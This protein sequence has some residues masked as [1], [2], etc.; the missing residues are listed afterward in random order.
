M[1]LPRMVW[2]AS[3]LGLLPAISEA[4]RHAEYPDLASTVIHSAHHE[5]Q[6]LLC[7]SCGQVNDIIY[8]AERESFFASTY[9]GDVW[10]I[11]HHGQLI[12]VLRG[13]GLVP[14]SGVYF[15]DEHYIDWI[16]SGDA[17]PKAY[18]QILDADTLSENA[19]EELLTK[20]DYK[21]IRIGNKPD[22]YHYYLKQGDR[23]SLVSKTQVREPGENP[24]PPIKGLVYSYPQSRENLEP[25]RFVRLFPLQK[26]SNYHWES[27]DSP[28]RLHKFRR[29]GRSRSGFFDI[30]SNGWDGFYGRGQF[31]LRHL[32]ETL[33]FSAYHRRLSHGGEAGHLELYQLNNKTL[34]AASIGFLNVVG[35]RHHHSPEELGLYVIKPSRFNGTPAVMGRYHDLHQ[36][37]WWHT[38]FEGFASRPGKQRAQ[39]FINGADDKAETSFARRLPPTLMPVPLTLDFYHAL[40]EAKDNADFYV[41]FNEQFYVPRSSS[42]NFYTQ[43]HLDEEETIAAFAQLGTDASKESPTILQLRSQE[44]DQGLV[45]QLSLRLKEREITLRKA[46]LSTRAA[47]G[48]HLQDLLRAYDQDRLKR[49]FAAALPSPAA[50]DHFMAEA[51]AVALSPASRES[52]PFD[53]ASAS[54]KLIVNR[55]HAKDTAS[56]QS[57]E[58][59]FYH[60]VEQIYPHTGHHEKALDIASMGLVLGVTH[61]KP[62]VIDTVFAK[63]LGGDEM[64]MAELNNDVLL[65]NL[66]CYY[67]LQQQKD[68]MLEATAL[69]V[70]LGKKAAQFL[71]DDDFAHYRQDKEF[72]TAIGAQP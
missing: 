1:K 31:D 28:L 29:E 33:K 62:Q 51:S 48:A 39:I 4:N 53:L 66:A 67:A 37:Y 10:Q 56:I 27:A 8:L 24:I 13:Q 12:D 41:L 17:T 52:S 70:R 3:L 55:L 16:F 26:A 5:M 60:Y 14:D 30:N 57:A 22:Q 25:L 15:E 40:P 19:F 32:G 38:A 72:L 69:A 20:A 11:N 65:Y 34:P 18:A 63:L 6:R 47:S 71:Q 2:L 36:R 42:E 68:K 9:T 45:Y 61:N 58:T 43:L 23:W 46:S 49:A 50:D 44:F 7:R 54:V 59:L 21:A 64:N 35:E